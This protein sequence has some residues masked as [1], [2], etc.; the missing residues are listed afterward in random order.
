M[1]HPRHEG[2]SCVLAL[3]TQALGKVLPPLV[4]LNPSDM[5][6]TK[7]VMRKLVFA[8]KLANQPPRAVLTMACFIYETYAGAWRRNT[9]VG[10]T[11]LGK[12]LSGVSCRGSYSPSAASADA[13]GCVMGGMARR[14]EKERDRSTVKA[15]FA[16]QRMGIC[17]AAAPARP[18]GPIT[19]PLA[20][21]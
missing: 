1:S 17:I 14:A 10:V 6:A 19:C 20:A 7:S 9:A 8:H 11:E 4:T 18:F 15:H 13:P 16:L 3:L 2:Q 5:R 21:R 12:V